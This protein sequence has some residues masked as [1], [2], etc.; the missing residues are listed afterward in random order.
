MTVDHSHAS[1][2]VILHGRAASMEIPDTFERDWVAAARY[3]LVRV[4]YE[5]ADCVP[6]SMPFYG[7]VWRPD[8]YVAEPEFD[9]G[10]HGRERGLIHLPDFGRAVEAF[11][12][13]IDGRT[14]GSG[15]VLEHLLND[16]EEYFDRSDLRADT[17]E[18][19]RKACDGPGEVV[20]VG[21]SM[22][23]LVAYN[24]LAHAAVDF[25]VKSLVTC[26]S[27]IGDPGFQRH[28]AA[29]APMGPLAFPGCLRMWVNIWNDDDPATRI[30]E[31]TALFPGA[32]DIQSAPTRGRAPSP[33][34]PAAAHNGPD[35]LS[36][37]AL[38][39]AVQ[40]ALIA[41][42]LPPTS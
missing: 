26:G 11:G 6:I 30:H 15:R 24:V 1:R 4:E 34:N 9:D 27:P 18:I 8:E 31:L 29:I 35:Y 13:W 42:T 20:L 25:A 21:F 22:G 3:G 7:K 28:V 40:T 33:I 23:S 2:V 12:E 14:G 39:A 41:P 32:H 36:S 5:H 17:D 38:A 16:T 19:V 37:K 10:I